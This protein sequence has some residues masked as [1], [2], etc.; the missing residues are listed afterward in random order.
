MRVLVVEEDRALGLFLQKGL[1]LEGH[2]VSLVS[3]GHAALEEVR[4][5]P[6]NLMILDLGFDGTKV[7]EIMR[8][9]HDET[10]MLVLTGHDHVQER[11]RCFD[12]GADAFLM[13]PFSFNEMAALCRSLLRRYKRTTAPVTRFGG[14]EMNRMERTV[15]YEGKALDLTTT[16]FKLLEA[17]MLRQG[18]CCS[19]YEL[20]R[21]AWK[22]TPDLSTNVVDVYINYLRRKF[23]AAHPQGESDRSPIETV[24][25]M[26]YRVRDK[27]QLPR[28]EKPEETKNH[29]MVAESMERQAY[30]V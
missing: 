23:A 1:M 25:G 28:L 24:R 8:K 26:G 5:N 10:A 13:K 16:E 18:A 6:P 7:L 2:K 11:I 14:V 19:R 15:L 22:A 17:L 29:S 12:L 21:E 20:L 9:E 4:V 27:R 3:D 30:A